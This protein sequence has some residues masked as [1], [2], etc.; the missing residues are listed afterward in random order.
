MIIDDAFS[1]PC[2]TGPENATVSL[3]NY[4]PFVNVCKVRSIGRW[5]VGRFERNLFTLSQSQCT[6]FVNVQFL[7]NNR[8]KC[9]Q[10]KS[11][12]RFRNHQHFRIINRDVVDSNAT[13]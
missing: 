13:S 2:A 12:D 7:Q 5:A 9:G 8:D 6:P 11:A 4:I 1:R 10:K 3:G